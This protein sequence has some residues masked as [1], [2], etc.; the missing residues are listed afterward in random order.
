MEQIKE[1]Y[2]ERWKTKS[3]GG[4][5]N[6]K[7]YFCLSLF[8]VCKGMEY[9]HSMK[10]I[11]RDL[12]ARNV[13]VS[14]DLIIKIA[15]FGLARDVHKNDY[16]RKIGDGC[17]PV[18]WMAPE[19]LFQR[20]YTTRSDVWSFGVLLWEI[21]TLGASPYPSVP[22]LE[23]LLQLLRIGHRMERPA[24]CSLDVYM[25]M[26]ECW[27]SEPTKR[28]PFSELVD[29]LDRLLTQARE[30]DYLAVEWSTTVSSSGETLLCMRAKNGE[31]EEDSRSISCGPASV[32]TSS[33][34]GSAPR[35][36]GTCYTHTAV[37]P[38]SMMAPLPP[39]Q[40]CDTPFLK[41]DMAFRLYII[42][43]IAKVYLTKFSEI[44]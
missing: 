32:W 33:P 43:S 17:L 6:V 29:D 5:K 34:R 30:G 19:A 10:C 2:L 26:M 11:H 1:N 8:Q 3:K 13:L 7:Y 4:N 23:K 44:I 39:D 31:E 28:P 24:N 40:V 18:K 21:M 37:Q 38:P 20:T 14:K 36:Q 22:N 15:D 27:S 12:A 25:I 16:Y 35:D 41:Q 9:L 42:F